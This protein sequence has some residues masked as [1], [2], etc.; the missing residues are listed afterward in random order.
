M[1][2]S[3]FLVIFL[4]FNSLSAEKLMFNIEY[5]NLN[6][7]TV[8]MEIT[9]AEDKKI[10]KI[11]A[12]SSRFINMFT[13]N[14][15]NTYT[16]QVDSLFLPSVV[17]KDISQKNFQENAIINYNFDALTAEYFNDLTN[18]TKIYTILENTRDFFSAL[19]YIRTLD[20]TEN[21]ELSIDVAG[22]MM[23]IS[24]NFVA[25]ESIRTTIGRKN[26][27]KVELSF[28]EYDN[29]AKMRSDILTNN[30]ASKDNNLIFW[31]T[32]DEKQIPVKAVYVAKPF[33]VSWF[34]R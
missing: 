10:I 7:A 24:I 31:F 22:K 17:R 28:K 5:L 6:I 33:N 3:I 25:N 20:L 14:F 16:T 2:N 8:E 19:Y 4:L 34:V 13:N 26:T 30:I 23:V 1:K 9:E 27:N 32:N 21:H 29:K 15:R 18:K 11:V 12:E